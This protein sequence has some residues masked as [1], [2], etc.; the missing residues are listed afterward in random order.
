M[1][2]TTVAQYLRLRREGCSR[3]EAHREC[4]MDFCKTPREYVKRMDEYAYTSA[5]IRANSKRGKKM[6]DD[7][8]NSLAMLGSRK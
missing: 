6:Q 7:L 1:T 5:R 2:E 8:F 3:T 4:A